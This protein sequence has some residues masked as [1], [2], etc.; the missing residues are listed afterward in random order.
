MQGDHAAAQPRHVDD[1]AMTVR[2]SLPD[3]CRL[4]A[5]E[6]DPVTAVYDRRIRIEGDFV[7]ALRLAELFGGASALNDV[8]D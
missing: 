7:L 3:F 6:L 2:A 8:S 5:E 1:P 4:I